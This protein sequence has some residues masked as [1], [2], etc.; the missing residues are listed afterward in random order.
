MMHIIT[1]ATP[2]YSYHIKAVKVAHMRSISCHNILLVISILRADTH[3]HTHTH[4]CTH[5]ETK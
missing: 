1:K 3:T 2:D 5:K 4:T